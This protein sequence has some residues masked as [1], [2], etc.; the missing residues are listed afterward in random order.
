MSNTTLEEI[1]IRLDEFTATVVDGEN[2]VSFPSKPKLEVKLETMIEKAKK[3]IIK[4]RHYPASYTPERINEDI[5]TNY[6][7]VLVDLVL[8][9][10]SVEGADYQTQHVENSTNRSFIKKETILARVIPFCNVILK[11]E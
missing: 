9:D 6:Q 4:A 3:D 5:E 11:E 10:Y 1:R 2:V 8:Y 7:Q